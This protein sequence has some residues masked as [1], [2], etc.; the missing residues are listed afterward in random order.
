MQRQREARDRYAQ[1]ERGNAADNETQSRLRARDRFRADHYLVS[2]VERQNRRVQRL[3][4]ESSGSGDYRHLPEF[5][6]HRC[7]V[8]PGRETVATRTSYPLSMTMSGNVT[9]VDRRSWLLIANHCQSCAAQ[10]DRWRLLTI[11]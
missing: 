1:G 7:G 11:A 8:V 9:G 6:H 5:V 3:W 10:Y 2:M 4:R